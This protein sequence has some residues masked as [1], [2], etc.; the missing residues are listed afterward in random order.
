MNRT[1]LH[2]RSPGTQ[3]IYYEQW[4]QKSSLYTVL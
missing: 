4:A 2:L 3:N 1:E